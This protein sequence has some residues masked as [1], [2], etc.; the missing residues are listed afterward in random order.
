MGKK[1]F[2]QLPKNNDQ[3]Q[4]YFLQ[5]IDEQRCERPNSRYALE[6]VIPSIKKSG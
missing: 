2:K 6:Y 5:R 1:K 4:V 3:W